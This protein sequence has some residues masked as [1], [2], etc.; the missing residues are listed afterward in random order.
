MIMTLFLKTFSSSYNFRWWWDPT[1]VYSK[2]SLDY[3][4]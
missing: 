3:Y 4:N 1:S 2:I